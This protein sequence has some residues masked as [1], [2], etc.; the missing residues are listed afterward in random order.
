MSKQL[1]PIVHGEDEIA[2]KLLRSKRKTL[3]IAVYPDKAVVI[4]APQKSSIAEIEKRIHKRTAWIVRQFRFFEQF[5]PRTPPRQ[6]KNGEEHLYLGRK[7]Q[8][9]IKK[10]DVKSVLLKNRYFFVQSPECTPEDIRTLLE[11]WYR[12]KASNHFEEVFESCWEE[13]MKNPRT[14]GSRSLQKPNL[15]IRKMKT[16]WGSMSTNHS[17]TLNLELIKVPKECIQYVVV[18]ELCHLLHHNHGS[19]FY[20][21]LTDSLPDWME[22]KQKLELSLS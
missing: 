6:Y 2:F 4:K 22:R 1:E 19:G 12:Q 8:L 7:Y 5:E 16:R 13:F 3:E 15:K 14:N 18:H 9:R 17:L 10:T 21:L 11:G 20:K